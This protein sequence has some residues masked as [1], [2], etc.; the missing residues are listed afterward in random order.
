MK[1]LRWFQ[2][3]VGLFQDPRM[4]YLLSQPHG[5]SYFVIWFYLK[6]L[7]GMI[8]DNGCI[9]VSQGQPVTTE[10]LA[11]QLRRRKAFVEKV[12]D[13]FEQIDLISRDEAGFI[14]IVPWNEIQS[15]SRDEKKRS[16]ARERM[17]RYRQRQRAEQAP[18]EAAAW[19]CAQQ[20][21]MT[22]CMPKAR[23]GSDSGQIRETEYAA[24]YS[25]DGLACRQQGKRIGPM[26]DETVQGVDESLPET[27]Y[28]AS[29]G[30]TAAVFPQNGGETVPVADDSSHS[31]KEKRPETECAAPPDRSGL[32]CALLPE[33]REA[34]GHDGL[35]MAS[36]PGAESA[37]HADEDEA[38]GSPAD[39]DAA[40]RSEGKVSSHTREGAS[41]SDGQ[42]LQYYEALFGR[43]DRQTA[44][45]L[46]AFACRW[47]DEAVCRAICIAL[48]KGLSSLRYI[49][50]I[51]IHS[52]G[53]PRHDTAPSPSAHGAYIPSGRGSFRRAGDIEWDRTTS[54]LGDGICPVYERSS[55]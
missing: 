44:D 29:Y 31:V 53:D 11:R 15:F 47:S 21:E 20:D 17:R 22:G 19:T 23:M 38:Y 4:M 9:Y 16:D 14:R 48:K 26:P 3:K 13:V 51:L 37:S 42:A 12:L 32:V 30:K 8:N 1:A 40:F 50:A 2:T 24:P 7:A 45:A 34:A 5:D 43:A 27:E 41:P 54:G 52:N 39:A 18:C 10:L 49:Y 28:R 33:R 35:D 6:D 46:R 55:W 25:E 36:L